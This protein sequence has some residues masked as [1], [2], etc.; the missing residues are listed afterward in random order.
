MLFSALRSSLVDIAALE[1][2]VR[3]STLRLAEFSATAYFGLLM[4][5]NRL[6]AGGAQVS[7]FVSPTL[8]GRR[9]YELWTTQSAMATT[10]R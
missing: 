2:F 8:I 6:G 4:T 7:P 10:R 3:S 5:E 9:R 1:T